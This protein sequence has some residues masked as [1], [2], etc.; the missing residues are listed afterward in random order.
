MTMKKFYS[1]N[2]ICTLTS[3]SVRTLHYY[4]ETN[5]LKPSHRTH[6]GHRLYS[7]KDLLC[8]QQILIFKFLGFSLSQ[9]KKL[10]HDEKFDIMHSL[11]MQAKILAEES[12]RIEKATHFFNYFI[13]DYEENKKFDWEIIANM[14]A[15]F[16]QKQNDI[17]QW[18][19]KYLNKMEL[20]AF[21]QFAKTRTD[22]WKALFH[23][24]KEKIKN[25]P[26][27]E[28][29]IELVKK[30]IALADEAYGNHPDLKNK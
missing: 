30:W 2:E 12:A 21:S 26:D 24:V 16:K 28:P 4:D 6:K 3:V 1:I 5:I 15:V 23:E 27:T 13:H 19:Q 9:I 10:I 29:E 8:L 14:M 25:N 7:Q 20:E 22:K 11:K 17:Q 18:F